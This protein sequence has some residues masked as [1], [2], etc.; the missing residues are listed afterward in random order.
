MDP[1]LSMG[2]RN[3]TPADGQAVAKRDLS[4]HGDSKTG[5]AGVRQEW[6]Y[7]PDSHLD[8]QNAKVRSDLKAGTALAY[9]LVITLSCA[10][11][12]SKRERDLGLKSMPETVADIQCEIQKQFNIPIF[13]QKLMFG[14]SELSSKESLKSHGLRNG[15]HITVEYSSDADLTTVSDVVSCMQKTLTLFQSFEPRLHLIPISPELDA[16]IE[17][18]ID[19][20]T[21]DAMINLYVSTS[22]T[23][24]EKKI[25]NS[26]LFIA[27]GG[28]DIIQ[29]LQALLLRLPFKSMTFHTQVLEIS[30]NRLVW[31]LVSCAEME[32]AM[33]K[34][35]KWG[36]ILLSLYRVS[37]LP[38]VAIVPPRNDNYAQQYRDVQIN[39]VIELLDTTMGCLSW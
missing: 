21:I 3:S 7:K 18:S 33:M 30:L 5:V 28:L 13:D 24:E 36:N 8:T 19:Q 27:S 14:P 38:D 11:D 37:A 9:G 15:D 23:T 4:A 34:E 1:T 32:A 16:E 2:N 6:T 20:A 22:T 12:G 35:M 26:Q 31:A 17:Q 10:A 39:V 29:Q 25:V